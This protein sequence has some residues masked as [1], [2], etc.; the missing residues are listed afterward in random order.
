MRVV[1]A[2][3][4]SE[5]MRELITAFWTSQLIYVAAKLRL[6]DA[7]ETR[8]LGPDEIALQVS[9]QV[10]P[11]RRVMRAL[12]SVGVFRE[13]ARGRFHLATLG[14]TL[15]DRQGSQR[16]FALLMLAHYNWSA[17]AGLE[18]AVRTGS[19]AFEDV[20]GMQN[21]DY[22]ERHPKEQQL[23]AVTQSSISESQSVIISQAYNF[24]RFRTL[25]DVGGSQGHLLCELLKANP[26]LKGIL[27]DLPS[28]VRGAAVTAKVAELVDEGRC[29]V[30]G[31]DF[32][33]SV[34]QGAD[35]YIMKFI[36]HDWDDSRCIEILRNC[37]K[38]MRRGGR[39]LAVEQVLE[40]GNKQQ[41]GKMMDI[42]MMALT[43]GRERTRKEFAELFRRAG[44]RLRRIVSAGPVLRILEAEHDQLWRRSAARGVHR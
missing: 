11:I 4:A 24:A 7:I 5:R 16:N 14:R 8:P 1:R 27:F 38:A 37:R 44:L 20:H 10:T 12:A 34:P 25:V 19:T 15:L 35:G 30:E 28:V 36:L 23:F 17:F 18:R 2:S 13:D 21:F 42:A 32:F 29:K 39:L 43:G 9:A 6:A 22:Y 31:G 40:A 33:E 41:F 3:A 26:K